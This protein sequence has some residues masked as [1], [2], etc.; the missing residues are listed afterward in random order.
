MSLQTRLVTLAQAV[1]ADIKGLLGK[2]GDLLALTTTAKNNLVAAINEA[3]Q[4]PTT[5]EVSQ[6]IGDFPAGTIES[7]DRVPFLDM[8]D[9]YK[10]KMGALGSA[11]LAPIV[12]TVSQ[13]G[14]VPT[15]A[16][17]QRGSNANGEFVRF[18][19]GTQIC[20]TRWALSAKNWGVGESWVVGSWGYPAVFNAAPVATAT[21]DS[22]Y[23]SVFTTA[24]E[25]VRVNRIDL[26][27]LKNAFGSA[28]YVGNI[29]QLFA[30]GRWF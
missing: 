11:A 7:G 24:V 1:G 9:A 15:G 30:I 19:D 6:A 5:A 25:G 20:W 16:I 14:G 23:A 4:P 10:I 26:I 21:N 28:G 13:T 27:H 2:Q 17:M 22:G 3:N 8:S 29:L 18:A 12:G